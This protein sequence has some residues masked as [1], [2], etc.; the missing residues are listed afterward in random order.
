M[1]NEEALRK[2][3]VALYNE[4][5]TVVSIAHELNRS[6]QW[7]HKWINRCKSSSNDWFTSQSTVPHN[8]VNKTSAM[9]EDVIV[10]TRQM[11]EGSPYME[12]G[13]YAIWHY[14]RSQ[15]AEP[16]SVATI[17]RILHKYGLTKQKV[18]YQKSGIEYPETPVNTQLMDLIGPRYIRGGHR[19]YLFTI[20]SNDTRYAGVYPI[21]SK[22]GYDITQSIVSFWKSYSIPDY[23]QMDNELS[24]KGSNRHPRGLGMLLRTA[25][26]LNVTPMF[27]PVAEPWRNGVIERF[28]QKVERTLLLQE[29]RCFE[30]LL[31]HSC[32]FV[33]THNNQHSY[34]TLGHKTPIE[35][36]KEYAS[37]LS[38]LSDSFTVNERLPL[39]C[40]N[41]NEIRFIRLIRSDLKVNIL[42]TEISV[43]PKLMHTYVEVCLLVNDHTLLIKQDGK[44]MQQSEF[45]MPLL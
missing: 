19:Y 39:D 12:S 18:R 33:E 37:F 31:E 7:V 13:A 11:L 9:W 3:A 36:T 29:H 8:L 23:L 2:Q 42:N 5:K 30:E 15:G 41:L 43:L 44:V 4:G 1:A 35:L 27:I 38:P 45:I 32:R 14:L 26:N 16:P 21:L 28:N 10:K 34:S 40:M 24:F 17:N 25:L 20:I 22:S 6:R